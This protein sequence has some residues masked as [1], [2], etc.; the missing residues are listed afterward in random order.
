MSPSTLQLYRK[1][2]IAVSDQYKEFLEML[3]LTI[4][5]AGLPLSEP[6]KPFREDQLEA[7]AMTIKLAYRQAR[8]IAKDCTQ[9]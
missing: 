3:P 8:Q 4:S 5:L 6:G 7:R 9:S 2:G 1:D